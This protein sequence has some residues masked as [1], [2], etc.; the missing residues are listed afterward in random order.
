M[1]PEAV[2][3]RL[4]GMI[5]VATGAM[6]ANMSEDQVWTPEA[7]SNFMSFFSNVNGDWK[8]ELRF[9]EVLF[10]AA[11]HFRAQYK[12]PDN[13]PIAFYRGVWEEV[14]DDNILP[15]KLNIVVQN[16]DQGFPTRKWVK[17]RHLV[18][19]M[20]MKPL[21][22]TSHHAMYVR[23]IELFFCYQLQG[24]PFEDQSES[25]KLR[26]VYYFNTVSDTACDVVGGVLWDHKVAPHNE[27]HTSAVQF[28]LDDKGSVGKMTV[29][30]FPNISG[31]LLED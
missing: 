4:R 21:A 12:I 13:H 30:Y 7:D 6:N 14:P 16:P 19:F 3:H 23:E 9:R 2:K 29:S 25:T 17:M 5:P 20:Y 18:S 1:N 27:S 31:L 28:E 22:T 26:S 15:T 24:T 11:T 8:P 10:C